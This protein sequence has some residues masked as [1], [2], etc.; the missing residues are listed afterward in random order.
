MEEIT[1]TKTA[2]AVQTIQLVDGNFTVS[3]ARDIIRKLIEEKINF[4][5]IQRL[6]LSEGD[7]NANT[8]YP[9]QRI[10][11]LENE[12]ENSKNFFADI[13]SNGYNIKINGVLEI[14]IEE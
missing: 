7:L 5:K 6:S 8:I 14:S 2:A 12:K 3:E 4:H 9:D 13:P 11:E 10:K 1:V